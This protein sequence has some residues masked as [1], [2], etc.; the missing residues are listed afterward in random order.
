MDFPLTLNDVYIGE[1]CVLVREGIPGK[2]KDILQLGVK[3][4]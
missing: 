1:T 2:L 4:R 3:F